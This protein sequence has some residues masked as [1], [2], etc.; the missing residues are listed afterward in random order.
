MKTAVLTNSTAFSFKIRL[1]RAR[2]PGRTLR[3]CTINDNLQMDRKT[4]PSGGMEPKLFY[5]PGLKESFRLTERLKTRWSGVES[6]LSGQ[7]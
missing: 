7:K 6:L 3:D 1:R 5:L 4:A 2:P